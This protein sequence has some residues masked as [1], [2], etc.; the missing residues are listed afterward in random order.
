MDALCR[1]LPKYLFPLEDTCLD[2]Q[3]QYLESACWGRASPK[4]GR[5]DQTTSGAPSFSS[6]GSTFDIPEKPRLEIAEQVRQLFFRDALESGED[7]R[8]IGNSDQ[9][10]APR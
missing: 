4:A 3:S 9:A 2:K 10:V 1:G 8:T 7:R 6:A 5:I